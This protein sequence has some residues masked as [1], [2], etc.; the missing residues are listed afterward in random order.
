MAELRAE[1]GLASASAAL[2]VSAGGARRGDSPLPLAGIRVLE[3]A[4]GWAG[5]MTGMWLGDLG[6]E[7]IKLEA[8]QRF[9]HARG[10][11]DVHPS[12]VSFYPRREPGP[13]PYDVNSGYVQANRNKLGMTLDLS[14]EK[15]VELFKRLVAVS[16]VVVTNMVTGVPEKMGIGYDVLSKI[17]PDLVMLSCSGFG[18]TGPYAKRVTMGGAMDGIAG[19]GALRH[20]PDQAPDTVNYSTH[21]DVVT[22][23]TN[24]VAILAALVQRAKTG[25]GQ[26]VEVSG[27]EASLHHVPEALMD[28]AI[29]GRIRTAAGND[30]PLMAP[31][32]VYPCAGEERWIA[33]SVY[34]DAQWRALCSAMRDPAWARD[35]RF[36]TRDGRRRH[37]LELDR[38]LADWTRARDPIALMGRLQGLGVPAAAVHDAADHARDPHFAARGFH[39]PTELEGYGTFPLPTSPWILD[40]QRLGVRLPPPRLGE[41]DAMIYSRLLELTEG[42][43]EALRREHYF[44]SVPLSHEL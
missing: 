15:G 5:P 30:H 42:E 31:H 27:V 29:S 3:L 12:L 26:Q 14:R 36:D 25:K 33:L 23:M 24:A 40:G 6:A 7:V 20:Y 9:D 8:V 13:R 21:T 28:Y 32:G 44:G 1:R 43:I 38:R 19:Y 17:R 18:L 2:G 41:H 22:G 11:V 39:Q 34:R 4:E 35:E 10:S 16:D 37:R